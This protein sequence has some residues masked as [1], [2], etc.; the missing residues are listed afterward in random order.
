[1]V[2]SDDTMLVALMVDSVERDVDLG[3]VMSAISQRSSRRTPGPILRGLSI[4]G[5]RS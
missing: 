1:M 5:G 3:E 2:S 4:L